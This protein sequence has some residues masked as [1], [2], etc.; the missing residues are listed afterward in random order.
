MTNRP[1]TQEAECGFK[2]GDRVR[3]PARTDFGT[4]EKLEGPN[5]ALVRW[6]VRNEVLQEWIHSLT[7]VSPSPEPAKVEECAIGWDQCPDE[8]CCWHREG[9]NVLSCYAW[10]G[11]GCPRSKDSVHTVS[12]FGSC[13][14][15]LTLE[16]AIKFGYVPGP[17]EPMVT[18]DLPSPQPSA[19]ATEPAQPSPVKG[20]KLTC[21][22][23]R[24]P[25]RHVR[26][27][28]ATLELC[29][30]CALTNETSLLLAVD[31]R[32]ATRGAFTADKVRT[33]KLPEHPKPGRLWELTKRD[34]S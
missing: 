9:S 8:H 22:K 26:G 20:E 16:Q 12:Q 25:Y 28:Y 2:V 14:C 34:E 21:S 5:S 4:V 30:Y 23:C 18:P 17:I 6:D 3:H 32:P 29:G 10:H 13:A 7:P 19:V 1:T 15:G 24:A 33:K 31:H 11:P 27:E